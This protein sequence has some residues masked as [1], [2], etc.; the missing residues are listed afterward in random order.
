MSTREPRTVTFSPSSELY[1]I[2]KDDDD[3]SKWYSSQEKRR[4]HENFVQDVRRMRH[5]INNAAEA[6]PK[7]QLHEYIGIELYATS[8]LMRHVILEK[9]SHIRAVLSEQS[10]QELQGTRDIEKLRGVSK[11]SSQRSRSRAKK[12]AVGYGPLLNE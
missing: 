8:G 2:P 12:L 10:S 3:K 6:L 9:Q 4:S 5:A 1:F 7:E 11:K